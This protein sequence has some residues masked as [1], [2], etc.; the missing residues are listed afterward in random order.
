MN[1]YSE[2]IDFSIIW[3]KIHTSLTGEEEKI[4]Q[5]W[6][7]E[8]ERHQEYFNKVKLFYQNGSQFENAEEITQTSWPK[9]FERINFSKPKRR[10]RVLLYV[11][12]AAACALLFIASV[13]I[14]RTE[15]IQE[16]TFPTE[17]IILPGT[18]K[19]MLVLD[20]GTSYDLSSGNNLSLKEGGTEIVSQGTSIQYKDQTTNSEVVKYNTLLIPRGGQFRVT[21]S[22][23]T[24]VWLNAETTLRYPTQFVGDERSVELEGEAYFE[25]AE[26]AQMP[27]IVNSGGQAV[28][29]LGTTFNISSYPEGK[30][31][32]TTLVE[33]K[34]QVYLAGNANEPVLLRPN[35]QSI[36]SKNQSSI[37]IK[38]VDVQEYISWK[39]G[40]FVFQDTPF[41]DIMIS[42][43]RWYDIDVQFENPAAKSMVFTGK[44]RRYE[45][46]EE[47]LSLLEKTN[48]ISFKIERRTIIVK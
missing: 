24:N 3:K 33:G 29:V 28:K 2:N 45:S 10:S 4:L 40:W 32:L 1:K 19:A 48:E 9:V 44:V 14:F 30:A 6:L 8:S 37:G 31:I 21:L 23:G 34:V 20:D 7:V 5:D 15:T 11:A 43:T 46:L 35:Q 41:E 47:I 17:A 26:N 22:D 16:D 25:V 38:E 13:Y 36:F 39:D 18:D 27:F 12:S 42:L